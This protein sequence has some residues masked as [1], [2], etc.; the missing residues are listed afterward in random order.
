MRTI[1]L[2]FWSVVAYAVMLILIRGFLPQGSPQTI[3]LLGIPL[4]VV[5]V[6]IARELTRESTTPTVGSRKP[7]DSTSR[8]DPVELL[9]NQLG[10]AV[11]ASDSYFENGIRVRLRELLVDKMVLETGLEKEAF[12]QLWD[13]PERAQQLI[14]NDELY[15]V[16][17]GPVPSAGAE[18]LKMIDRAI[19]MIEEWKD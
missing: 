11:A 18:R 5:A 4:L 19:D 2:V 6:F 15:E 17:R 1:N 16:L 13:D 14:Q 3:S 7:P 12:K 9:R 8:D 10:T